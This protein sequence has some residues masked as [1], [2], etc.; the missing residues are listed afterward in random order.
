[1]AVGSRGRRRSERERGPRP[2]HRPGSSRSA[3]A[4]VGDTALGHR[5]ERA[6]VGQRGRGRHPAVAVGRL[7]HPLQPAR[8]H[9]AVG[10]EDHHVGRGGGG[11]RA[12]DVG[13][14]PDVALAARVEELVLA[15]VGAVEARARALASARS[16]L[17]S[18]QIRIGTSSGVCASTLCRQLHEVLVAAVDRDAHHHV[19]PLRAERLARLDPAHLHARD[20]GAVRPASAACARW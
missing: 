13:R 19:V 16:G 11:E 14:K 5:D 12:V 7:A 17:A 9:D 3:A 1:M 4:R 15:R 10:V 8:G 6:V 2:R 20:Y 18:S